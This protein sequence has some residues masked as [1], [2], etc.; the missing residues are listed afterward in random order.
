MIQYLQLFLEITQVVIFN[1]KVKLKEILV[2]DY[3]SR[4]YDRLF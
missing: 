3:E 4:Y 2:I 1:K